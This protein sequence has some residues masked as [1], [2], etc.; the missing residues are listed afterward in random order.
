MPRLARKGD[1]SSHGGTIISGAGKTTADGLPVARVGDLHSC[2]I[3]GHGTTAISSGSPTLL[4]EGKAAAR[5]GDSCGCG[6]VITSGS[7]DIEV[8]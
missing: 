7:P 4:V 6:A 2:P 5:V 1:A 8:N 3:P